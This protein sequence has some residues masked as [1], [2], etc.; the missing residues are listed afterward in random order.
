MS[1][2]GADVSGRS[3]GPERLDRPQAFLPLE[4]PLEVRANDAIKVTI[5]ARHIDNVIGWIIERPATGERFTH[6]TFNGMLL[7]RE[8]LTRAQAK[9]N[10][11]D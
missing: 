7:G 8:A 10:A 9:H 4:V 6:T 5:M 2:S 11:N 1:Q 3:G